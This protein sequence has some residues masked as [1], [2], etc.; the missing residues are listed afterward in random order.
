MGNEGCLV[1]VF[2]SIR[3]FICIFWRIQEGGRNIPGLL[4]DNIGRPAMTEQRTQHYGTPCSPAWDAD[5]I[6]CVNEAE[7]G[8][9]RQAHRA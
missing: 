1:D 3:N 2:F 4:M 7:Q 9:P 6:T 8:R 5:W